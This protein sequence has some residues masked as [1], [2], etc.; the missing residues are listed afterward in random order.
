MG[1]PLMRFHNNMPEMQV[2]ATYK[3]KKEYAAAVKGEYVDAA[4]RM[5]ASMMEGPDGEKREVPRSIALGRCV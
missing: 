5:T 3:Y 4:K 1:R 2:C